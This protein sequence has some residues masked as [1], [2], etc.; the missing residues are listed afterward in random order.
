MERF[1]L[2]VERAKFEQHGTKFVNDRKNLVSNAKRK[3]AKLAAIQAVDWGAGGEEEDGVGDFNGRL[4]GGRKGLRIIVLKH[5]FDPRTMA[6]EKEEDTH[7]EELSEKLRSKCEEEFGVVEKITAFSKNPDGVVIV[8]FAL[9][10]A[11]SKAVKQLDGTYWEENRTNLRREEKIK[12]SFWDGV[13]DYTIRD[14]VQEAKE[15]EKRH[16][17]FGQWLESQQELPEELRLQTE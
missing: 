14:E 17:E 1:L 13:T 11:A 15:T 4:T 2:H 6:S 5:L 9:P 7:L 16:E 8:K 10:S 12:A 3:V